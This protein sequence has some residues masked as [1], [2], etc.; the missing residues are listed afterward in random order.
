M[1]F[2]FCS[3][4]RIHKSQLPTKEQA[5]AKISARG[6][7]EVARVNFITPAGTTG[8]MLVRSD[9]K[10]LQRVTG[11]Y[12]SGYK[13]VGSLKA[14]KEE[15]TQDLARAILIRHCETKGWTVT[16]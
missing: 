8:I 4:E 16:K 3:L 5:V 7:T 2:G 14:S 11:E 12:G 1:C 13:V 10:V 6:A 15:L 9:R